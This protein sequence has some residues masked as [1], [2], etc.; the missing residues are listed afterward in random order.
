M[1][2]SSTVNPRLPIAAN[3]NYDS[4]SV[5]VIDTNTLNVVATIPVGHNPQDIAW[6][7]DGRF[8][9]VVNNSSNNVSVIDARTDKV[10]T[11]IPTGAG[12][13]PSRYCPTPA[14]PT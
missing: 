11:I 13:P 7:P 5:S 2:P 12:R 8:A 14:T 10:T 4:D 9:Y 3:V 6:A 1:R